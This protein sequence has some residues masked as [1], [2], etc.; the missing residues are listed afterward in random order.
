MYNG[1]KISNDGF[2]SFYY[3]KASSWN[4]GDEFDLHVTKEMLEKDINNYYE[5]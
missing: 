2:L 5:E 3:H 1:D 4:I